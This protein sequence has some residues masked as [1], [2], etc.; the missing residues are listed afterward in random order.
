MLKQNIKD[1]ARPAGQLVIGVQL[2]S[3]YFACTCKRNKLK[4]GALFLSVRYEH[5]LMLARNVS[6]SLP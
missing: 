5:S 3:V 6:S 4:Q 1:V 2:V